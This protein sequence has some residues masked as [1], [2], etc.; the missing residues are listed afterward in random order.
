MKPAPD[1]ILALCQALRTT[2]DRVAVIGDAP[3]DMAMGRAAGV[4]L[5]IG[6]RTGIG[7]DG[8]LADANVIV[9]SVAALL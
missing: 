8:D 1:A 7:S 9:E 4:G 6:V 2:P 3:A 5:V